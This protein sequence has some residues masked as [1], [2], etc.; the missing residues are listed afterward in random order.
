MPRYVRPNAPHALEMAIDVLGGSHVK[1]AVLGFLAKSGPATSAEVAEGIGVGRPTAKSHLYQLANDGVVTADP[2][3]G[4]PVED[5]TGKRVRYS[6]VQDEL[7]KHYEELGRAL[8]L[9]DA[10]APEGV[11]S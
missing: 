2:A 11:R 10:P 5:R 6:V 8:N 7:K 3:L 9:V 1:I 4:L